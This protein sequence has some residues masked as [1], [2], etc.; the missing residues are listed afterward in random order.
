MPGVSIGVLRGYS[1]TL[2]MFVEHESAG[3]CILTADHV[4]APRGNA[5]RKPIYQPGLD[6][7]APDDRNVI[8]HVDSGLRREAACGVSLFQ[9]NGSRRTHDIA[10]GA[11]ERLT[12]TRMP[13]VGETLWKSGRTTGVTAAQVVGYATETYDNCRP[14]IVLRAYDGNP[15]CE[16]SMG[17]DSGAIWY[18]PIS[19]EAIGVHCG[20]DEDYD[21][22]EEWAVAAA[23]YDLEK[24]LGIRI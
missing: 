22:T 1:G 24:A 14:T 19:H 15:E 23:L 5:D 8:G 21:L 9:Y 11:H 12:G 13:R 4:L 6:D 10:L 17:G 7:S 18:D 2:G 3:R 20:G 16:I